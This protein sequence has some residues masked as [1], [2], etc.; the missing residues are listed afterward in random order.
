MAARYLVTPPTL[1][2]ITRAA[3]T[4]LGP[5]EAGWLVGGCLRDE[6]LGRR[7]RDVDIAVDGR[8][9]ALA[10]AL[11]DRFGGGVYATSDVFGT[12][13]VVVGDL[14]IDIAALRGGPPATRRTRR[15]APSAWRRTSG[16]ATSPWTRS[17]AR[18]TATTSSTR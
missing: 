17:R 16:R 5:G 3:L 11:G 12:W 13:R 18:S 10:R 14:H 7:V 6:L 9:E 2:E 8:P 15:R 4:A 1:D